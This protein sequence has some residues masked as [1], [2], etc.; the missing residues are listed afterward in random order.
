MPRFGNA[1]LPAHAVPTYHA[2]DVGQGDATV[3]TL[4]GGATIMTDA[5]PDDS[6][7]SSFAT[8]CLGYRESTSR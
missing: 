5:G 6:V 7:V 2:L 1:F 3:I 8:A 4:P